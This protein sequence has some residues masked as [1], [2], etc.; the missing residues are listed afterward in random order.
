MH[1]P[2]RGLVAFSFAGWWS[3]D[4]TLR[5]RI[6]ILPGCGRIAAL[7]T[8]ISFAVEHGIVLSS[9]SA[10]SEA[11]RELLVLLD[12]IHNSIV[13]SNQPARAGDS[14]EPGA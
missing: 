12:K 13:L 9:V 6:K 4:I 11:N 8:V 14:V 2:Q 3:R 10:L 1:L 5:E 7:W